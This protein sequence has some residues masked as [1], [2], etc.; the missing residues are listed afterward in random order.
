MVYGSV[1]LEARA[2]D[3]HSRALHSIA[4]QHLE[5][6]REVSRAGGTMSVESEAYVG[7]GRVG[8]CRSIVHEGSKL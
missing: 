2:P 1:M 5:D 8:D 6:S 7:L 4:W 3:S